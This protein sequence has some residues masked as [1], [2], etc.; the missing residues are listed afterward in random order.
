MTSLDGSTELVVEDTHG[1][2]GYPAGTVLSIEW[3][4]PGQCVVS[5]LPST[6]VSIDSVVLSEYLYNKG[7]VVE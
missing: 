2:L 4:L 3:P 1:Y 5:V 7:E 6:S